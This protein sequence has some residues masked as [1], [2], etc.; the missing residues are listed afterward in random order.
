MAIFN[1]FS[2]APVI[3]SLFLSP[4]DLGLLTVEVV[5]VIHLRAFIVFGGYDPSWVPARWDHLSDVGIFPFQL[6]LELFRLD[7]NRPRF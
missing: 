5:A 3:G 4:F 7:Q 6:W 1:S 2:G